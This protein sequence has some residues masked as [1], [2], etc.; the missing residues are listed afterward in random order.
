MKKRETKSIHRSA[1]F[2]SVFYEIWSVKLYF[3]RKPTYPVQ[4]CSFIDL[5]ENKKEKEE[6]KKCF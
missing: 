6:K 3:N 1:V 5:V 4:V 2:V